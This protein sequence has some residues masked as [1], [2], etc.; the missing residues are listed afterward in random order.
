MKLCAAPVLVVA[1]CAP[2]GLALS[3]GCSHEAK[4][5]QPVVQ[6]DEHPPLP[7]TSGTPIGHLIDD[8]GELKLSGDQVQKLQ[9]ISDE[10]AGKLA[11]DDS[12]LRPEPVPVSPREDKPRGL[13]FR[14]GG[15]ARNG[16]NGRA[17]AFPG[18]SGA[19]SPGGAAPPGSI[20]SATAT[21]VYQ[22]R[23]H[24]V[25]DAIQRALG[26]LDPAQQATA[27][28]VLTE[29]G[30]NLDTGEVGSGDPGPVKLEDPKLGQPLPRDPD[31]GRDRAGTPE[32][33]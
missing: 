13:G 11:A 19:G 4:P 32:K 21:Q 8:A 9:A 33:R 1:L 27:R 18:A 3:L 14:A 12:E 7:P 15:I 17:G 16:E 24:H 29:H 30:V 6:P 5:A 28:R 22:Q 31:D 10:L 26:S 25:R 23:A 2:I 20:T